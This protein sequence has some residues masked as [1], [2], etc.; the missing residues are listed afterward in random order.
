M[1]KNHKQEILLVLF[2]SLGASAIYSTLSLVRKLLSEQGLAGSTTVINQAVTP[3][4]WLDLIYQLVAIGLAL[5]PVL[6]SLYLL[7]QD[8]ISIGLLPR[9]ADLKLAIVIALAI[10]IPGLAL[11]F[12][13]LQLGLTSQVIPSN[14]ADQAW[15]VPLLLL[16]ALRSGLQEEV[17]VVGFLISKLRVSYPKLTMLALVLISAAIRASYHSYQGFSAVLGNFVMGIVFALVFLKTNRVAPLVIA[18]TLMNSVVFVGYP[19]L[20]SA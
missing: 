19:L 4:P 5:V 8:G 6:L 16:S 2:L 17:I 9:I 13:A 3:V 11:Y 7:G 12:L 1:H 15:T 18:H 14:L 10:G 20:F